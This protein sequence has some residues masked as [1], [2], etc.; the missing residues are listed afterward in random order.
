M[1][2][3]LTWILLFALMAAFAACWNENYPIPPVILEEE[4][5]GDDDNIT[6]QV[7]NDRPIESVDI[8]VTGPT[9]SATPK[10]EAVGIGNFNTG[11]VTWS[12]SPDE[13]FEGGVIYTAKVTLTADNGY[14]FENLI[15]ATING[16][17]A[18]IL[19]DN[20]GATVTVSR[21]FPRTD[22]RTIINI[23]ITS[24][25]TKLHYT[26]GESLDLTGLAVELTYDNGSPEPVLF[27]NFA[28]KNITTSPVQ[29]VI[30]NNPIYDSAPV[31]ITCGSLQ[32]DTDPLTV[33]PPPTSGPTICTVTFDLNEG[34]LAGGATQ[35][36]PTKT[37]EG[38]KV[39]M[40]T[41]TPIRALRLGEP[42][43]M[44]PGQYKTTNGVLLEELIYIEPG[45]YKTTNNVLN[46]SFGGWYSGNKQWDFDNDVVDS[47]HITLKA[48]Y[49]NPSPE[50]LGG[51]S[52]PTAAFTYINTPAKAGEYTLM[53]PGST[54]Y[55]GA[56]ITT[57]DTTKSALPKLTQQNVDLYIRSNGSVVTFQK[58]TTSNTDGVLLYVGPNASTNSTSNVRVTIGNNIV[59]R[60]A[61]NSRPVVVISGGASVIMESNSKVTGNNN[62]S[63]SSTP[64]E[65]NFRG[66][67][68][69]V[70]VGSGTLTMRGTSTI[71]GNTT[72]ANGWYGIKTGGVFVYRWGT[73]IMEG[74]ASVYGN[75][76]TD[77]MTS[78]VWI[79]R[80]NNTSTTSGNVNLRGTLIMREGAF[81]GRIALVDSNING[82]DNTT[83]VTIKSG[84][85]TNNQ[86]EIYL[87]SDRP[88]NAS[89]ANNN[90]N[91]LAGTPLLRAAAGYTLTQGDVDKFI[92]QKRT[93]ANT[94]T[95]TVNYNPVGGI[96]LDN[97]A[98]TST[99]N[100]ATSV[101]KL[102]AKN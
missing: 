39:P 61:A 88:I 40:P 101:G 85:M 93:G 1:K 56:L 2:T 20:T 30:L 90:N 91:W 41:R 83:F 86:I 43:Y 22:T 77:V 96:V 46:Q 50:I 97:N 48:K 59:L 10:T 31:T 49:V 36:A 78:D 42:G 53:L 98:Q 51:E 35:I 92:L 3:K 28:T 100:T 67:G 23:A 82:N 81:I 72:G 65:T 47:E 15:L 17:Q 5:D 79:D 27:A 68:A 11:P 58:P 29:G 21:E 57:T 87:W 64:R 26:Y 75:N 84:M 74:S 94:G 12:P 24:Q 62:S 54:T 18:E 38:W 70:A 34:F 63:S 80:A 37:W 60:G 71:T 99:G 33:S 66:A 69:A 13:T 95:T 32:T 6:P 45:L 7:A 19:P 9:K 8:F 16:Q 4:D 76:T 14:T 44:E 52:L 102:T 73:L 55:T 25:P 89:P